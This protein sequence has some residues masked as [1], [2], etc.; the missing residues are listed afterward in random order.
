MRFDRFADV[1]EERWIERAGVAVPTE[2]VQ[3]ELVRAE[4]YHVV[5][6]LEEVINL[7]LALGRPLLLQGDPGAGKTRLAHHIAYVLG[8]PLEAA[9]VKSTSAARDLLYT[10]DAVRRL[11]DSQ[12]PAQQGGT[13]VDP[14]R[15]VRLGPLGRAI[16]RATYG[17]MSVV[18]VDEIDKADIDYPNDLLHELD[19]LAFEVPEAEGLGAAVGSG[20]GHVR[21]LV[22]VTNNEEKTLPAAFLRRCIFHYIEFPAADDLDRILQL[23]TFTD[24]S[25]RAAAIRVLLELREAG[26]T[27]R[28]GL[29]ELID[30]LGYLQAINAPAEGLDGLPL[31]GALIKQ[32]GDQLRVKARQA[33]T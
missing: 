22:V 3:T 18:L 23:H 13:D 15:Y 33:R 31:L 16:R 2:S 6:D 21:P 10:F 19:Q 1:G 5:P 7:A 11:F 28:P 14:A 20:A 9:H 4:P 30:W 12:L 27:R 32:R 25:L 8:C 24:P 17:R 29:S 26:L